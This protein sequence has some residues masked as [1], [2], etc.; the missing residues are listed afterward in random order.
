MTFRQQYTR[1]FLRTP[2]SSR[3]IA[4]WKLRRTPCFS[5]LFPVKSC[6]TFWSRPTIITTPI[7]PQI[8]HS[9]ALPPPLVFSRHST[10]LSCSLPPVSGCSLLCLPKCAL[11]H[12]C[13]PSGYP[14]RESHRH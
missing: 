3:C 5:N 9:T 1:Q 2:T 14:A 7:L 11:R 13:L 10:H 8:R 6:S 4:R 12:F